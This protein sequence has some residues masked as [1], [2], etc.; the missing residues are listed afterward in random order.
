MQASARQGTARLPTTS[1]APCLGAWLAFGATDV[2]QAISQSYQQFVQGF[3]LGFQQSMQN[4]NGQFGTQA[5][6]QPQIPNIDAAIKRATGLDITKDFG[7][8]GDVGGFLQGSSP[9][10]IGGGLVIQT[11]NPQQ[12][13]V[14][15]AKLRKALGRNRSLKITPGSDGGFNI[16][17]A[18]A[19]VGAK[20]AIRDDKVVFA[21]AGATIDDVL[22]P[23]QTLGDA[24]N[25]KSAT[26]ALGDG[27]DPT[28]YLDAPT[29]VQLISNSGGSSDPS[30]Q[31]AAP[32]LSAI[33]YVVVGNGISGDRT[34]SRLVLGLK[35]PSSGSETTAAAIQP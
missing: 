11:D 12:A 4:L 28:F 14:T 30:Y 31:Q 6:S 29:L 13:T 9:L 24:D 23:S 3:E 21:F 19:P 26:G 35:E 33:N 32:Y 22:Q 5:P 25:F 34:T 16:E 27:I 2:G 20:V 18:S 8:N 7:W 15:L 17:S 1:S 10:D